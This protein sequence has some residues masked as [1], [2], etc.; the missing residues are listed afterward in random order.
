MRVCKALGLVG[1]GVKPVAWGSGIAA[2]SCLR[3]RALPW[4]LLTARLAGGV[5]F[6][7]VFAL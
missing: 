1:V 5:S 3:L 2:P 7:L 6:A 4:A